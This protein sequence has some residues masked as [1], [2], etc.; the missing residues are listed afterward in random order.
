MIEF[1]LVLTLVAIGLYVL[2]L[3]KNITHLA[4]FTMI[5]SCCGL[6]AVVDGAV[7]D[8]EHLVIFLPLIY[9]FL[10]SFMVFIHKD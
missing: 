3:Y 4:I 9:I 8:I 2:M 7:L 10:M 1:V 5:V 6:C